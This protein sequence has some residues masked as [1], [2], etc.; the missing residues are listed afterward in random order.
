MAIPT[1]EKPPT[2]INRGAN[3][4]E[5]RKALGARRA[6]GLNLYFGGV[7]SRASRK[8]AIDVTLLS[9]SATAT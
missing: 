1:R 3:V 6:C 4:G 8:D 2:G 5:L 7:I 9:G